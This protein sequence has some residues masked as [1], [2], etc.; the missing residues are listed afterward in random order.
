[1]E[2]ASEKLDQLARS[3]K[4]CTKCEELVG[5]RLRALSGA[6][7][8]HAAVMF[9]ALHPSLEDE[10]ADLPAGTTLVNDLADFMPALANGAREKA[11]FTT[12]LKCVPRT[13]CDLRDPSSEEKDNCFSFLSKELSITTPHYVV[14]IGE[15]TTRYLLGRLFKDLPYSPGDALE[16]RCFDSPAFKVIPVATPAELRQR[17]ARTQKT[18]GERLHKLAALMGL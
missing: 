7:H 2:D 12:L 5:C 14:A 18:Y 1:M 4:Q 13:D 9:V 17:D 6:G 10:Q 16:L 3:E 8:P 11:Y 15:A